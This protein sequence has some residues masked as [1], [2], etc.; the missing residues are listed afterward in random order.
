[1]DSALIVALVETAVVVIGVVGYKLYSAYR[2]NTAALV[3]NKNLS[4]I[5]L[6][7]VREMSATVK[8]INDLVSGMHEMC[9]AQAESVSSTSRFIEDV[10]KAKEEHNRRPSPGSLRDEKLLE[11]YTTKFKDDLRAAGLDEEEINQRAAQAYN[12]D[13]EF[14]DIPVFNPAG[15]NVSESF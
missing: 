7:S 10:V 1:M 5:Y 12:A 3:N 4:E 13:L 14:A 8:S 6:E 11:Y 9:R 15:G 2:D